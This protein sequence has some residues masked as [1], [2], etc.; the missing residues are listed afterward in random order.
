MKI[1]GA[2][3]TMARP[4]ESV[5]HGEYPKRWNYGICGDIHNARELVYKSED[6]ADQAEVRR[7]ALMTYQIEVSDTERRGDKKTKRNSQRAGP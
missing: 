2:F 3:P 5:K 4:S 1:L 6:A 7:A